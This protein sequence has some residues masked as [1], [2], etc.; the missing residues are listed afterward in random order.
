MVSSFCHPRA[1]TD[2]L[3]E[4]MAMTA[5]DIRLSTATAQWI[6]ITQ[7][8][9]EMKNKKN[10]KHIQNLISSKEIIHQKIQ[11][12]SNPYENEYALR[13]AITSADNDYKSQEP[14][15]ARTNPK[16]RYTHI[17]AESDY[18]EDLKEGWEFTLRHF[19]EQYKEAL[20]QEPKEEYLKRNKRVTSTVYPSYSSKQGF[21][22]DKSDQQK[23]YPI[24]LISYIKCHYC[25]L[26][27]HD[28][29]ERK[30]HELEWH[31]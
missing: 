11:L 14:F 25:N 30:D 19:I 5:S 15:L 2:R 4:R 26:E 29:E 1:K 22:N 3:N 28:V 6:K 23:Y 17:V 8:D 16:A 24:K 21:K 18:L 9:E 31:I 13:L 27:F 7:S 12:W 20:Q 10:E